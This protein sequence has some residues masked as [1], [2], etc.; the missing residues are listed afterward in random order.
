M[1]VDVSDCGCLLIS[2][3]PAIVGDIYW[4]EFSDTHLRV[5][6]LFARCMRCRMVSEGAFELGIKFMVP[7]DLQS[8]LITSQSTDKARLP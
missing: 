5:G 1:T 7:I 3:F 2:P 6:S 8:T 4:L